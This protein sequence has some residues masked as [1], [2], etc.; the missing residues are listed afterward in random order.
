[1][2]Y[3]RAARRRAGLS[4]RELAARAGT[5]A[6]A[7]ARYETGAVEPTVAVL[8]RLLRACGH[9]LDLVADAP[10]PTL[11]EQ[12]EELLAL[13][14][15]ERLTGLRNAARLAGVANPR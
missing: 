12:A 13:L 1:M 6:S 5:S 15:A 3:L 4:Q 10:D 11:V 7:V 8:E 9:R 14:P 2:V